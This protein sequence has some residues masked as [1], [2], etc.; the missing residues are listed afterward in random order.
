MRIAYERAQARR[1]VATCLLVA[2]FIASL[3]AVTVETQASPADPEMFKL[4]LPELGRAPS[5]EPLQTIPSANLTKLVVHVSEPL[6]SK[7]DYSELRPKLNA[8]AVAT[9]TDGTRN[10]YG[11]R[12]EIHLDRNVQFRLV[13]GRNVLEIVAKDTRQ[14]VHYASFVLV[15]STE[16]RNNFEFS[17]DLAKTSISKEPPDL[18]LLEPEGDVVVPASSRPFKVRIAG[19]V[20]AASTVQ[21][22]SVDG[23]KV[24]IR[25]LAAGERSLLL[26]NAS[27]RMTFETTV[28]ARVGV[29]IVVVAM[30]S[31]G[32]RTTVT[33]PVRGASSDPPETFRGRKFALLIG[34][35]AFADSEIN[36][37]QFADDDARSVHAFL[38]TPR[39]GGFAAGDTLLLTDNSASRA[40]IRRAM[41]E[42]IGRATPDDLLVIFLATHGTHDPYAP[43][44][45]YFVANDTKVAD[46]AGTGFSMTEF[47]SQLQQNCR[48]RRMV[49]LV[50]A[51]HGAGI[52]EPVPGARLLTHN[53][54]SLYAE[55]LLYAGEGKAVLTASDVTESSLENSRWG[56]GHGVFTH[57]VLQGLGGQ[58]DSDQDRVVTVEELFRFVRQRVRTETKFKQ[59]PRLLVS[60]N[61]RLA[62]SAVARPPS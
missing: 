42:F 28:T 9:V 26:S 44:N 41:T 31:D 29:P 45:L 27:Q 35:S 13:P 61:G 46:I 20:T 15:T 39:G 57:F 7:V 25:P 56:G 50:D 23:V 17:V 37:L 34:I 19:Q 24:P 11:K 4:E 48:A 51:C 53:L 18:V 33:V 58:A 52:I 43:Q 36:Q 3:V 22:L 49:L 14:R 47:Y 59:N 21:S 12:F 55:K 6:A 38:Q 54:V 40:A 1:T 60:S 5:S 32:S 2:A 62:M 8:D 10:Q 16:N 30:D